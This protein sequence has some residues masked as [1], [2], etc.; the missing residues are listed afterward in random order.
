MPLLGG[1]LKAA[2]AAVETAEGSTPTVSPRYSGLTCRD[3]KYRVSDDGPA[4]DADR[5]LGHACCRDD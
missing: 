5:P 2:Q 3:R 1:A 4:G